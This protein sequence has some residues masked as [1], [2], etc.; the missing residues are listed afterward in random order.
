MDPRKMSAALM[1]AMLFLGACSS[2]SS[3]DDGEDNAAQETESSEPTPTEEAGPTSEE[4]IAEADD[5]CTSTTQKGEEI[6]A[7]AGIPETEKA[8][9]ALG[10]DL[11]DL[12]RDRIQQL[13]ALE[14]P[15]E[16]EEQWNEYVNKRE[17]SFKLLEERY[18]L[19]KKG[20]NEEEAAK[21]LTKINKLDDEWQSIGRE[22]GF[23]AC[24]YTLAAEDK[25]Q[26]EDLVTQFFEGEP[27]KTCSG[28]LAKPYLDYLGGK[29]GCVE[30]LKT[31]SGISISDVEGVNGVSASAVIT[32][33]A[34]G[35]K[36]SVEATYID[37]KYLIRT[38]YFL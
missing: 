7:A 15:E 14:P 20:G 21:L 3:T 19:I 6:I 8:D 22:I 18:G 31:G 37:G 16:L 17:A 23:T 33:S 26:V 29:K 4:F 34:Y 38:F 1:V 13:K 5:V 36:G 32:G 28:F 11:L 27:S 35:K 12:R 2:G 24:A 9:L 30:S 10:Q 25:K